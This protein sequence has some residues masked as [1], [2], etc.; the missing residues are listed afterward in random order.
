MPFDD[1]AFDLILNQHGFFNIEEIK[2]TLVPG[3]VFLSQQVDGQN[4]ADLARAFDVSY[5]STYSRDEVCRN[6]G[7]LGFDINR[8]ETHECTNDFT[9]VGATV[10]LLT[11]I[12]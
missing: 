1:D 2:R 11:A 12:P 5:D 6:I 7:A 10:Y 4:M 8:S 3:G 9:D